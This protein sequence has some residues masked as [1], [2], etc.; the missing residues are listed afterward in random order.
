[1]DKQIFLGNLSLLQLD[2][3]KATQVERQTTIFHLDMTEFTR[4]STATREQEVL[5]L[6][7]TGEQMKMS[8]SVEELEAPPV[9]MLLAQQQP[10]KI[11]VFYLK[12]DLA[13]HMLA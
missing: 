4:S 3:S 7:S 5:V 9:L 10:D 1:L 6:Q 8:Q 12:Q 11:S 13:L 2:V